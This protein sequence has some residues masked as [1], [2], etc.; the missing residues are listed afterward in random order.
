MGLFDYWR[1]ISV[2]RAQ[3]SRNFA[4]ALAS[5]ALARLRLNIGPRYHS[6]FEFG[7][8]PLAEWAKY[9]PDRES[10]PL[11]RSVNG[12]GNIPLAVNKVRFAIHCINNNIPTI[13]ILAVVGK[14]EGKFQEASI[15]REEDDFCDF[16][17]LAPDA[18]FFK[19]VDGAHGEGA[20][21]A[22]RDGPKWSFG[23][24]SGDCRDLF[25]FIKGRLGAAQVWVVQ[26]LIE[27]HRELRGVIMPGL[28]G[29]IRAVS[30]LDGDDVRV[31]LPVLRIP[32]V[33]NSTDNFSEGANG[34]IV[35][36]IDLASGRLGRGRMSASRSWPEIVNVVRHPVT[37]ER[38]EGLLVPFWEEA[39]SLVIRAQKATP[40]LKTLGW[41]LAITDSGPIVVEANTGYG[42]NILQVAYDRG[43][44][45]EI[46]PIIQLGA[47]RDIY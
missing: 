35:A 37:G 24:R 45:N 20:F 1:A 31:I 28:L 13:R 11:I 33:G 41:D 7:K 15:L 43:V 23:G 5:V 32:T 12:L 16:L 4:A 17:R 39:C 9:I 36:P 22:R 38:I 19:A 47:R 8:R 21:A 46:M 25:T 18:L 44:R 3:G 29:T 34:N 14:F 26:P 42:V 6:L 2:A 10:N 40:M 27:A 30:Y